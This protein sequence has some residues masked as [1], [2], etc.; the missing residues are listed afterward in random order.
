MYEYSGEAI[1]LR[2]ENL[3]EHDSR[4]S[5]LTK[6]FGKLV[7]KAKSAR[8]LTSKLSAHLEPG[9]VSELRL[10]E[11]NDLL[12]V[13]ALKKTRLVIA[14]ADLFF[15]DRLLAE[16]DPDL[17]L[18]HMLRDGAFSWEEIL[19]ML[20]WD[21]REAVCS[22]CEG[23]SPELIRKPSPFRVSGQVLNFHVGKQIFFCDSCVSRMSSRDI[24]PLPLITNH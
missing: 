13:D 8:K 7:A 16:Q 19:R 22:G 14:P 20:G 15:V 24:I 11:K 2:R 12:V 5:F 3:G 10:I 6:K 9:T 1:V 17:P 21:P 18:W 4:I 23:F